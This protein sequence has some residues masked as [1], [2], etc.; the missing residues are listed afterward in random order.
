MTGRPKLPPVWAFGLWYICRTQANDFEAVSDA[1]NFRR[2]EIPCDVIG[3]E[4]GWM[5]VNY[6]LST[7]KEWSKERFPIPTQSGSKSPG[8]ESTASNPPH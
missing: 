2:E 8:N 5:E 6:D 3:L 1:L 7:D 4:P